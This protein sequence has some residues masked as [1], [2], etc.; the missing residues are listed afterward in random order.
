MRKSS[1]RKSTSN[2]AVTPRR[3]DSFY[4][5]VG[6]TLLC[7]GTLLGLF[8][9]LPNC[10]RAYAMK[11]FPRELDLDQLKSEGMGDNPFVLLTHVDFDH[12]APTSPLE[13]ITTAFAEGLNPVELSK[14][15]ELIQTKIA[16]MKQDVADTLGQAPIDSLLEESFRG[17]P[18]FSKTKGLRESG[19]LVSL[20]RH[21][22]DV[23]NAKQ[24]ID[25]S[26]EIRGYLH[27]D[28]CDAT[29]TLMNTLV[30][31]PASDDGAADWFTAIK[32]SGIMHAGQA[33]PDSQP[34][35]R[36]EPLQSPPDKLT[37][38][39]LLIASLGMI[40][41]GLVLCG[42]CSLSIWSWLFLPLP[43][44]VSLLGIPLR[45]GR[46][47]SKTRFAYT[48]VGINLL[49]IGGYQAYLLGGFGQPES[50]SLH[51][52]LGFGLIAIGVAA[53][54]GAIV[55]ARAP[56]PERIPEVPM[57]KSA[58]ASP[59]AILRYNSSSSEV[60]DEST[61][62]NSD[63][64]NRPS[65]IYQDPVVLAAMDDHVGSLTMDKMERLSELGFSSRAF[66]RFQDKPT[67]QSIG[68][69]LGCNHT[70][71]AEV[72][73]N[74][75]HPTVRLTSILHDGLPVIT[76]SESVTQCDHPKMATSG[77]YQSAPDEPLKAMLAAHLQQA[78]RMSEKRD[79]NIVTIDCD[80]KDEVFLLSHRAFASVRSQHEELNLEVGPATYERFAF[81]PQ[82]I[83]EL[84]VTQ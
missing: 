40:A 30:S 67:S 27:R 53:V 7:L 13:H 17:I 63:Q 8:S 31:P 11:S 33:H 79:S 35:Y 16:A 76:V 36:I 59:S 34:R 66:A 83:P 62:E 75:V 25:S 81:P 70:V 48:F 26:D 72:S 21:S 18:L 10:H 45:R 47:G 80:E 41:T 77:V 42:T 68:L 74:T 1:R 73:D 78:I 19:P 37:S 20:S 44:L 43:S 84:A 24:Q 46:G 38:A 54:L 60:E 52:V 58:E 29:I 32:Q 56:K 57:P 23:T 2:T 61:N 28:T 50:H 71:L 69:M 4:L 12:Q 65:K 6:F 3:H 39:F 9:G 64:G 15:P 55:N 5:L 14:H 49:M 51:T 22:R 82:P